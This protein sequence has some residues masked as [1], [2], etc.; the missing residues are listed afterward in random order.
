[1]TQWIKRTVSSSRPRLVLGLLGFLACCV[2]VVLGVRAATAH[3]SKHASSGGSRGRPPVIST[4]ASGPVTLGGS[5]TDTAALVGV[6]GSPSPDTVTFTVYAAPDRGRGTSRRGLSGVDDHRHGGDDGCGTALAT[7]VSIAGPHGFYLSRPFTPS[8]AGRYRWVASFAGDRRNAGVSDRCDAPGETSVVE[9]A[10][11]TV[12]TAPSPGVGLGE[13]VWDEASLHS[14]HAASGTVTFVLYRD[15]RCRVRVFASRSP[16]HGASATSRRYVPKAPGVFYWRASYS[17][18]RDNAKATTPC[19]P[20]HE[21]VRVGRVGAAYTIGGD[22]AV[23]L[24]PGAPA[25]P[26]DVSFDNP[27]GNLHGARVSHLTVAIASVTGGSN[28]PYA[29]TAGDFVVTQYAGP[30]PFSVPHGTSSLSTI[31]PS[32]ATSAYPSI[33]MIDRHDTVPG[34]GTGNQDG[35]EGATVHLV[36]TGAP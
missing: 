25:Q 22:A 14:G 26:I 30:Y 15:R 2:G 9:K 21:T 11:P 23:P 20:G 10:T 13:A 18:D 33:R 34:D 4:H 32:L 31:L 6:R 28:T 27:G 35:C 7:L 17:G 24:Y 3:A 5:I 36:Y 8:H 19:G 12:S 29:C 16:L 1:M